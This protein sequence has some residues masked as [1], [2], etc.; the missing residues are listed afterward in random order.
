M[1]VLKP[2]TF[3]AGTPARAAEV[4]ADFDTIYAEVNSL[5]SQISDFDNQLTEL[6]NTKADINGSYL[7]R[8]SVANPVTN[9]DAVNKQYL[10]NAV[11]NS[12]PYIYGLGIT[13]AG[14]NTITVGSGQCYDSTYVQLLSLS[15]NT[16]KQNTT[17]SA[18]TTY[19]VYIIGMAQGAGIDILITTLSDEPTLPTDYVY[20][21]RIGSYTTNSSNSI[22]S[23]TNTQIQQSTSGNDFISQNETAIVDKVMPDYSRGRSLGLSGVTVEE[24]GWIFSQYGGDSNGFNVYVNGKQV[25]RSG[26]WGSYSNT[27]QGAMAPVPAGGRI[28]TSGGGSRSITFYPCKGWV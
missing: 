26:A 1:P 19:Y 21:R 25:F 10:F 14:D 13:R 9:Y 16:S 5:E 12:L 2:Y 17:Q 15:S 3:V 24:A 27:N 22:N 6:E 20:Y 23:I 28:T 18:S 7:N 11:A 4:N 8:F